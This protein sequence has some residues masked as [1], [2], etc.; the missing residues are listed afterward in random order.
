PIGKAVRSLSLAGSSARPPAFKALAICGSCLGIHM[1]SSAWAVVAASA[2][3]ASREREK[4]VMCGHAEMRNRE[5]NAMSP[6]SPSEERQAS[7]WGKPS[8]GQA[9]PLAGRLI[10]LE[11]VHG[12]VT[13]AGVAAAVAVGQAFVGVVAVVEHARRVDGQAGVAHQLTEAQQV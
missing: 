10:G 8:M 5:P 13:Q 4:R 6:D 3:A 1:P 9:N 12:Q 7:G 11:E 2:A